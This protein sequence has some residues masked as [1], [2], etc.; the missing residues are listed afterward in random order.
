MYK[1]VLAVT[2]FAAFAATPAYAEGEGRIEARGGIA[3]A[4]GTSEAFAGIGG[5]YDFD[6]GGKAFI[7][8][9]VGVLIVA[10]K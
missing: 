6:L 2:V 3:F 1:Q 10:E 7:G 9:D 4:G 8:L 5:G